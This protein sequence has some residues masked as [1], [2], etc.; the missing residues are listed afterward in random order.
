MAE[1]DESRIE[2]AIET[3]S[4]QLDHRFDALATRIYWTVGIGVAL[5]TL[6]PSRAIQH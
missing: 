5:L 3:M 1:V 4:K 6:V 2:T